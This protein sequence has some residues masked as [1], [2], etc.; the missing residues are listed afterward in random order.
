MENCERLEIKKELKELKTY[1]REEIR[2]T[3]RLIANIKVLRGWLQIKR[4]CG[5]KCD[6]RTMKRIA[7]KYYL[8]VYYEK[9]R[10]RIRKCNLN[11]WMV[12]IQKLA[13]RGKER[14]E[15]DRLEKELFEKEDRKQ[16]MIDEEFKAFEGTQQLKAPYF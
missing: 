3:K 11:F 15:I 7:E 5:L 8:S 4:F 14:A 2:F 10:P 9:G 13:F 1:Y 16:K 6:N 12:E